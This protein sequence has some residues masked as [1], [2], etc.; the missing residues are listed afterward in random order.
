MLKDDQI[1]NI[2]GR[3]HMKLQDT[4]EDD[5]YGSHSIL[6]DSE[7][8]RNSILVKESRRSNKGPNI[9]KIDEE[10]SRSFSDD[11]SIGSNDSEEKMNAIR[12]QRSSI[13]ERKKTEKDML[14]EDMIP[15]SWL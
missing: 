10:D 2:S 1:T 4:F 6:R 7:S 11:D 8:K 14:D 12:R 15:K 9:L 3:E 5:Y 13:L